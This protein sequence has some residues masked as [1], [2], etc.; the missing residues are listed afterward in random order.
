M[1][2]GRFDGL[3]RS[4]HDAVSRRA[5]FRALGGVVTL[6]GLP[7]R[8]NA[9][10]KKRKRKKKKVKRNSFGCVNVGDFCRKNGQCCS[11][12]CKRRKCEP[13][14]A[15][16]CEAEDDICKG[17]AASC[18][19]ATN[20]KGDCGRTTGNAS[21]CGGEGDCFP[22]KKDA[23]CIPICGPLAA[24]VVCESECAEAGGTAC[25]GPT[26]GECDFPANP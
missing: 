13:H 20:N 22:C 3:V 19:T 7:G 24:C 10:A 9:S 1:D 6:L 5:A 12:L 11:G 15:D 2:A 17:N 26:D 25:F 16:V 23:D 8:D 4:L 21:Y 18:T 14:D